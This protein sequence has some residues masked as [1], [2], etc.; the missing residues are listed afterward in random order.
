M[1]NEKAIKII[2]KKFDELESFIESDKKYSDFQRRTWEI[3]EE[4]IQIL[5]KQILDALSGENDK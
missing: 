5:K 2:K 3:A 4:H 1:S